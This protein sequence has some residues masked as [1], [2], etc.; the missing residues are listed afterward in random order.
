M[1]QYFQHA[2]LVLLLILA[3]S[4]AGGAASMLFRKLP[5]RGWIAILLLLISGTLWVI[6]ETQGWGAPTVSW[7]M[8][9]FTF[10]A[11]I[12]VI[13]SFHIRNRAPDRLSTRVALIGACI[14]AALLIAMLSGTAVVLAYVSWVS[15]M[16]HAA[17]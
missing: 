5:S 4:V 9:F 8:P 3:S 16:M 6:P 13:Y 17:P 2:Q 10:S 15:H 11:P 1:R 14:I 7:P 12:A